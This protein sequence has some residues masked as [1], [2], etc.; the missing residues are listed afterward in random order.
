MRKTVATPVQSTMWN[1][2]MRISASSSVSLK[3]AHHLVASSE[4]SAPTSTRLVIRPFASSGSL[5]PVWTETNSAIRLRSVRRRGRTTARTARPSSPAVSSATTSIVSGDC[6]T[7]LAADG[8]NGPDGL[9]DVRGVVYP[10]T[11]RPL[12]PLTRTAT[13]TFWFGSAVDSYRR[14][15]SLAS[16][17]PSSAKMAVSALGELASRYRPPVRVAK[18]FSVPASKNRD[19]RPT[20]KIRIR[21]SFAFAIA[22]AG[23]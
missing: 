8:R 5:G 9:R 13:R 14:M 20:E 15:Y 16:W 18:A 7:R 21:A 3:R 10:L 1:A 22:S 12:T 11:A 2:G 17:D 4:R 6:S 19:R 23:D